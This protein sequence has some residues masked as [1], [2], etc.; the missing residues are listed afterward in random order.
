MK[1][2]HSSPFKRVVLRAVLNDVSPIVARAFSIAEDVESIELH[3]IF[4]SMLGWQQDLGF[5]IRVHGQEFNSYRRRTRSK[6]LRDFQLRRQEKFLYLCNTLDLWEWESR[7][8]DIQDGDPNARDPE[9]LEGRGATPPEHCGG[10]RGY[11][12]MLKRQAVGP[13]LSDPATIAAPVQLLA[14]VY[15]EEQDIDWQ[16]VE[17]TLTTG[18]KSVEERLKRTGPL[19]PTRFSRKEANDRLA[20]LRQQRRWGR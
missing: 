18:W 7:V 16:F 20:A 10:P 6:R 12:L 15:G 17:E 9:C 5:I 19:T 14:Q 4:L 11:R 13:Q 2:I 8:L 1:H 3:D